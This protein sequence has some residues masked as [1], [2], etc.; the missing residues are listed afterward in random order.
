MCTTLLVL[1]GKFDGEKRR[2]Q[3]NGCGRKN[4]IK[5]RDWLRRGTL[6]ERRHTSL[7]TQKMAYE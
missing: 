5:L 7:L 6:R 3:P 2:G 1:E 4:L